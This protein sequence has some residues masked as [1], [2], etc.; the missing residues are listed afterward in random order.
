MLV[1]RGI[2][3]GGSYRASRHESGEPV[4]MRERTLESQRVRHPPWQ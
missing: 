2:S 3:S 1:A 4:E